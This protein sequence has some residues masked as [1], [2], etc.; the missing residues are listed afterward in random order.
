[1][2]VARIKCHQG[3]GACSATTV[4]SHGVVVLINTGEEI[5]QRDTV[6]AAPGVSAMLCVA[7]SDV[8]WSAMLR[9]NLRLLLSEAMAL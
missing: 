5:Q 3:H 7:P 2:K 8:K 9:R 6:C 1:M 4:R